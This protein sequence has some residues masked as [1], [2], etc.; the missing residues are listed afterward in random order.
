MIDI[1][2][3]HV[4]PHVHIYEVF[5]STFKQNEVRIYCLSRT[6]NEKKIYTQIL[7]NGVTYWLLNPVIELKYIFVLG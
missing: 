3:K 6:W 2:L 1:H 5:S 4:L 7:E